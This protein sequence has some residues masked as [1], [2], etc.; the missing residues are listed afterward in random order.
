MSKYLYVIV[1]ET[2]LR[3]RTKHEFHAHI[4]EDEAVS[5]CHEIG[6]LNICKDKHRVIK[7]RVPE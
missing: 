2:L 6:R 7:V 3:E 1:C 5:E 4:N